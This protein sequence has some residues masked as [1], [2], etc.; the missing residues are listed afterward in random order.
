MSSSNREVPPCD[1][2]LQRGDHPAG[3]IRLPQKD[4]PAFIAAF[5]R[6]Y[7]S[8]GLSVQE[9]ETAQPDTQDNPVNGPSPQ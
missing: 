9:M 2:Y 8:T 6:L 1:A 7:R 5:N 4:R 3:P